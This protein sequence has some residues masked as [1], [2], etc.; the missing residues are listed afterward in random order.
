V[1]KNV[2]E[3]NVFRQKRFGDFHGQSPFNFIQFINSAMRQF[4]PV[5]FCLFFACSTHPSQM[6]INE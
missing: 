4:L 5:D 2:V 3:H 1:V 6:S